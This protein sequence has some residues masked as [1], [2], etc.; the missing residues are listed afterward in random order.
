MWSEKARCNVSNAAARQK[1]ESLVK[2]KSRTLPQD[3]KEGVLEKSGGEKSG[4][5]GNDN[6]GIPANPTSAGKVERRNG[7]QE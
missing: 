7:A 1:S 6:E 4:W 2:K 3:E 5:G